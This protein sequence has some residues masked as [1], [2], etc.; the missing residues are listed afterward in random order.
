MPSKPSL[1][2]GFDAEMTAGGTVVNGVFTIAPSSSVPAG[3]A[4]KAF[5]GHLK[6]KD[7][8]TGVDLIKLVR[9]ILTDFPDIG[10][11]LEIKDVLFA[12][13]Q[14]QENKYIFGLNIGVDINLTDLPLAGP[15]IQKALPAGQSVGVDEIQ[16]LVASE[17]FTPDEVARLQ[18]ALSQDDALPAELPKGF[19]LSALARLGG[20]PIKLTLPIAAANASDGKKPSALASTTAG[21]EPSPAKAS[22]GT[23]W[24]QLHKSLGPVLLERI[25]VKYQEGS[26]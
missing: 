7:G 13:V 12:S 21:N 4:I 20:D 6:V 10:L 22:D 24:I 19:N 9:S 14:A 25:G 26:I 11:K 16:L 2:F 5:G 23:K 17:A 8:S 3:S 15:M 18:Q 1:M